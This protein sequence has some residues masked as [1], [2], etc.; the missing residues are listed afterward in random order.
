MRP[1]RLAAF[2]FSAF[3]TAGAVSA[4]PS[5]C[6]L[7]K[8]AELAVRLDGG[9]PVVEGTLNGQPIRVAVSTGSYKTIL[10]EA[11]ARRLGLEVTPLP[12]AHHVITPGRGVREIGSAPVQSLSIGGWQAENLTMEVVPI[13]FGKDVD[14]SLGQDIFSQADVELDLAHDTI[15]FFHPQGCDDV[16]LAYWADTYA[17]AT[18]QY[19]QN[20]RRRFSNRV[21]VR[22]NGHEFLARLSTGT[23]YSTL[24]DTIAHQA[25]VYEGNPGVTTLGMVGP[26]DHEKYPLSVGTFDSFTIGDETVSNV[27]LRFTRFN[28]DFIS[29]VGRQVWGLI[30]GMD[31]IRSHRIYIANSQDKLYFTN[32]SRPVFDT[33]SP[34]LQ[35]P[36][37]QT[38]APQTAPGEKTAA[39]P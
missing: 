22:L 8:V 2:A 17:E 19:A 30:L 33:Q 3:L 39:N 20:E 34:A 14:L 31:F 1:I 27:K 18:M 5:D 35:T 28:P 12:M 36:P 37:P 10:S 23:V 11:A 21:P 7:T 6:H 9:R 13:H 26:S 25:G 15:R 16:P 24:S 38:P 4:A 29:D 32:V